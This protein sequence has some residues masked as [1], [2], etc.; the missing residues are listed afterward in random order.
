MEGQVSVPS[1]MGQSA[2]T[3]ASKRT[4]VEPVSTAS[5]HDPRAVL[6]P[7]IRKLEK[8]TDLAE[9]DQEAILSLPF[10][11]RTL[12]AGTHIVRDGE[13]PENCCLIVSGFAYRHKLTGEGA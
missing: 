13:R 5:T 4:G 12:A 3:R 7:L 2:K 6:R 10:V 9:G 8:H 1:G 11:R